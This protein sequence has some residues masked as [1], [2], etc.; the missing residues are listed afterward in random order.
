MG[1]NVGLTVEQLPV[2]AATS[3]AILLAE[4]NRLGDL[5]SPTAV[6]ATVLAVL[7]LVYRR[8]ESAAGGSV[9]ERSVAASYTERCDTIGRRV[10]VVLSDERSVEGVAEAVDAGGRLIIRTP[11]GAEAF[12]AG[13]VVHLRRLRQREESRIESRTRGRVAGD[14]RR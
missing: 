6:A 10:R 13:D 5:P 9:S 4:R 7:E 3:L 12:S 2:P 11:A 1:I 8:W 14:L